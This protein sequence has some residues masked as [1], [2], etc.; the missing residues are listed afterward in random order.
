MTAC[1]TLGLFPASYHAGK[2][3]GA[4]CIR[5]QHV[6]FFWRSRETFIL[7]HLQPPQPMLPSVGDHISHLY[8]NQPSF[9]PVLL[10]PGRTVKAIPIPLPLGREMG[11]HPCAGYVRRVTHDEIADAVG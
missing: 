1:V 9:I 8:L 7:A 11:R 3:Q 6:D 10:P 5:S 4:A 2:A